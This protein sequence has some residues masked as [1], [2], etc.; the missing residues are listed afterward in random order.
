MYVNEF[1]RRLGVSPSTVRFYDRSGMYQS[2]REGNNYRDFT[3]NDAL[4]AYLA[5][6]MRSIDMSMEETVMAIRGEDQV[7][8]YD[9]LSSRIESLRAEIAQAQDKLGRLERLR[10]YSLRQPSRG[11]EERAELFQGPQD[12]AF[13]SI[14]TFGSYAKVNDEV[15][16]LAA[17]LDRCIPYSYIALTIPEASFLV[18]EE[19]LPVGVGLGILERNMALCGISP[20]PEM[21]R[22]PCGPNLVLFLEREDVFHLKGSDLQ[23]FFRAAE[24]NRLRVFGNVVGRVSFVREKDGRR[25]YG[26]SLRCQTAPL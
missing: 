5:Q 3:D 15:L 25:C 1:S 6:G 24:A 10:D 26:L 20:S 9:R 14:R 12:Q 18:R 8:L 23:P 2:R 7:R 17:A 19:V 4:D 11:A 16:E 13:Y 21:D 22:F